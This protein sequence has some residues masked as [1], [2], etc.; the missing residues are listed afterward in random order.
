[1]LASKNDEEHRRNQH[2][3]DRKG[4]IS[5]ILDTFRSDWPQPQEA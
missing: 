5:G 4:V 2:R 3:G 1:M